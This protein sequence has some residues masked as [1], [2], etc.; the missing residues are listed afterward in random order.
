LGK[1]LLPESYAS[2]EAKVEM[3]KERLWIHELNKN[4]ETE[5]HVLFF[6]NLKNTLA[7][8]LS[9]AVWYG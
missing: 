4:R 2:L 8:F 5:Y 3:I 6:L 1:I 7:S 9:I